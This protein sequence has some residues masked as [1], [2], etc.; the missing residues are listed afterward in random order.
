MEDGDDGETQ[1]RLALPA[2]ARGAQLL[3]ACRTIGEHCRERSA[4]RAML[5]AGTL[6]VSEAEL[7]TA[8]ADLAGAGC[9]P[10]FKLACVT[11]MR[12]SFEALVR[13]EDSALSHGISVRVF[14]DEDNARRWLDW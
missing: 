11:S 12:P 6:Q 14:F 9:L 2:A 3:E 4:M 10:G 13:V 1:L 7:R 8:F 5:I